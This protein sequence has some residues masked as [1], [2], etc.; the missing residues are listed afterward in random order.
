MILSRIWHNIIIFFL[1][2]NRFHFSNKCFVSS[3]AKNID[4]DIFKN[5]YNAIILWME[6]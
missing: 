1:N 3:V 2:I 6:R 4:S 5:W